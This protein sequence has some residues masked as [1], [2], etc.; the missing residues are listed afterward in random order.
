MC[1]Q[2]SKG[3]DSC[4]V[5]W[6]LRQW[7][8]RAEKERRQY[9]AEFIGLKVSD[10]QIQLVRR[11]VCGAELETA[12]QRSDGAAAAELGKSRSQNES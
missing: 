5:Y 6:L 3:N 8:R 9:T 4:N 11:R 1:W 2:W 7:Q 10:V 12:G